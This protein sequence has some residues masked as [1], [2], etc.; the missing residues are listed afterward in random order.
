MFKGEKMMRF[1]N[2]YKEK[3]QKYNV[4][5][6][7]KYYIDTMGCQMNENDS[8][9]YA[10]ILESMG[11]VKGNEDNEKNTICNLGTMG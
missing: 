11:F 5:H 9:K 8:L 1:V 4:E 3:M 6:K 7:L 10:G 2:S